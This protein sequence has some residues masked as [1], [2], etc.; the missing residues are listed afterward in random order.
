MSDADN[1]GILTERDKKWLRDEIEYQHRQSAANR[2]AAV[3]ERVAAALEDF[4]ELNENWSA[5]E[6]RKTLDEVDHPEDVAAEVIEFLYIWLN[7]QA[8]DPENMVGGEAV[9][10]ALTF[11]RALSKGIRNGKQHFSS[12][13]SPMIIDSNA[14]LFETPSV[15]E[16]QSELETDQWRT[17]N[18]H[19]RGAMDGSDD[20]IIDKDEAAEQY[21]TGLKL[22]IA[23]ELTVRRGHAD[24][25]VNRYDQMVSST[26]PIFSDEE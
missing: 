20:A 26:I 5:D 17:L 2:R 13:P 16:F 18:E 12:P 14:E 19:V 7:E 4:D 3:R 22:A 11:R 24:T 8:A 9:D 1:R 21:R 6:R 10:N 15:E 25:E 23:E